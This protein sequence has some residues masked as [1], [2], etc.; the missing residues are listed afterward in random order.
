MEAKWQ[1]LWDSLANP[2]KIKRI[3]PIIE[4]WGSSN[5]DNRYEEVVIILKNKI[6][7][8]GPE[9]MDDLFFS[10]ETKLF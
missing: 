1:T 9:S 6:I 3:K 7:L 10:S 2:N 4:D 5:R 8:L